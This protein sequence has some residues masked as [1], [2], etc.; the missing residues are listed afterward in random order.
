[1]GQIS[2]NYTE[3]P[4]IDKQCKPGLVPR[5]VIT[6]SFNYKHGRILTT[7]SLIDSGADYNLFPGVYCRALGI[8]LDKGIPVDIKGIGSRVP[9]K[10]YRHYG[11][12]IFLQSY[13]FETFIDF[14]MEQETALLGR[15][16]FFNHFKEIAFRQKED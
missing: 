6:F 8:K 13:S 11:V 15:D 4:G 12:K 14:C 2:L 3:L 16:G 10:G 5:P 1:M 9:L 7:K